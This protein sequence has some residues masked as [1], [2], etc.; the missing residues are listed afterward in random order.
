MPNNIAKNTGKEKIVYQG[1]IIEVVE[2]RVTIGDKEKTFEFARRSPGV[3]LIIVTSE[4]KILLTKE[5]RKEIDGYDFR[6]PGGK[7]F[8]ELSEYNN[9]LSSDKNII[10]Q[11]EIAAKKEALEEVGIVVDNITYFYTSKAGATVVWDLFYFVVSKY[12]HADNGQSLEH[13]EDI[14][15]VEADLEEAKQICL[16]GRMSEDRSA[17]VLMRFLTK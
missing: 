12:S 11:A 17:A 14:E 9:F 7:V 16:D 8:D 5:Y 10:E 15:I 1:R 3:R 2:Q 13:G 6:L 4:N